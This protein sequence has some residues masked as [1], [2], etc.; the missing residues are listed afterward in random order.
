MDFPS[1]GSSDTCQCVCCRVLLCAFISVTFGTE[2][3][4]FSAVHAVHWSFWWHAI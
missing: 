1:F 2:T 4:V 3:H